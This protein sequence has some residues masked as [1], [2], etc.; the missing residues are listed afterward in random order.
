MVLISGH[1]G[2]TG[3]SPLT[4]IKHAGLPWEL[5]LAETQQTLVTNRLRDRIRVQ[6]D[7]QMKT[8][9]DLAIAT[10]LGAEE[11]GFGSSVL[12]C[13][14]CVMVRKCHMNTCPV[15]IA[16]Q[17]PTLRERFAGKPEY[18]ERFMIFLAEQLREYMADLGFRSV[19]EMVGRVDMLH[20]V[21][22]IEHWKARGLDF[23]A[24]L[25][26]VS[27]AGKTPL[28]CTRKQDHGLEG[29]LDHELV[30]LC[31]PALERGEGVSI[32]M[33]IRNVHRTVGTMLSGRIVGKHG[34]RGLPDGTIDIS[35]SGSAGQSLGA[36]LAPGVSMRIEGD[37]ND[38][39]CKGLSGGRVVVVP[40]AGARFG[41]HEDIIAGNVVLYGATGGEVFIRGMVGERFCVRN[42]GATA[43]VEGVGDHGCEYMTGGIAVVLGPTGYN[44]AA[45]MSGGVAYV[46]DESEMFGMRCNL[47]MVDLETVWQEEDRAIL[48]DL[49]EKHLHHTGSPVAR[50]LLNNWEAHVPLFVKV[51]PIDYRKVLERMRLQEHRDTETV[52]ATEEVYHG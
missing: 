16:T 27:S 10:L 19:D 42:S 31:E 23:S 35:F 29:S 38:Y 12:V 5:G 17:D 39:L 20:V 45:G 36:W 49:V 41:S 13:L 2:G 1:D 44:F 4:S 8:G 26:P 3:A 18:V 6:A 25:A 21:P 9:R 32:D 7:G 47:D 15:G 14:G 51:M 52:P 48:R 37:A 40:P 34:S 22:A 11:F 50:T 46:Y 24:L 43:V 30:R 33:P 28:R